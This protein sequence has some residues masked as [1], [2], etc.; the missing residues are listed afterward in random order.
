[1]VDRYAQSLRQQ[2]LG[3]ILCLALWGL[4][5]AMGLFGVW[6]TQRGERLWT[7]GRE[8][9][10]RGEKHDLQPFHLRPPIK[11]PVAHELATFAFP[12]TKPVEPTRGEGGSWGSLVEF[13][14]P[15]MEQRRFPAKATSSK[16]HTAVS[17]AFK[18]LSTRGVDRST[19]S[20]WGEERVRMDP[21]G[22]DWGREVQGSISPQWVEREGGLSGFPVM[23][24][25]Q[26]KK[27]EKAWDGRRRRTVNPFATPFDAK[28]EE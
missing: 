20:A 25:N 18:N 27:V 5:V 28:D 7:R 21:F 23:E 24:V 13:F 14:R 1:M 16:L 12:P 11:C 6:W 19:T 22:D 4:V 26:I 8:A 3:F 2:R 10:E 15:E 9:P 17:S